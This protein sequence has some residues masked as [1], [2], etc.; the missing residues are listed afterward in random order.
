MSKLDGA[1]V[2]LTADRTLMADYHVLLDGMIASSQTTSTPW[3]VMDRL[4]LPRAPHPG[5]R[6]T[7]APLGLR[8]IEATLL[9]NGFDREDVVVADDAHLDEAIGPATRLVAISSGEPAGLGMSSTTMAGIAGGQIYPQV[10]FSRLL[11]RARE[12]MAAC[13]PEARLLL[14]GPGAWQLAD[15][16]SMRRELGIDHVVVGYAEGNAA[17]IF[18]SLLDRGDLPEVIEGRG[19]PAAAVPAMCGAS[20]MGVVE[21]SRGCGLGCKF[22]TIATTPMA[23]LPVETILADVETNLAAGMTSIAVLSEDFFRHGGQGV[24]CDPDAV[25]GLLK[26]LRQVQGLRLIQIDHANI[27]SI[28][29]YTDAELALVRRLLVGDKPD[30]CAW[31]NTGVETASGALLQ[32]NGGGLKMGAVAPDEWGDVC[33]E[34]LRRLSRAGFIPMASLVVGLPGETEEDV[35]RTLEWVRS[36]SGERLTVFPVFYAPL[37]G[38]SRP[39]AKNLSRLQW[40][41]VSE[42]YRFNFRWVPKMYWG[43]QTG[44]GVGLGK[45]LLFQVLSKAQA[46]SWRMHLA[47]HMRRAAG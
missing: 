27:C 11:Q 29:Q 40:Q 34:Q 24:R 9:A 14:G 22:C 13:A 18:A 16:A 1:P 5:G 45:R 15:D 31:V 39:V 8:R 37:D 23:D 12:L 2:V 44:A 3:P 21:I 26:R 32:A 20:T 33:A 17:E 4:L 7:V 6:A 19:V 25:L 47:R 46:A 36:L 42:C 28:A 30:N 38:G 43:S 10:M 41:L 35:T